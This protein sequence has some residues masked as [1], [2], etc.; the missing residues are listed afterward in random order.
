M[1]I[2]TRLNCNI[3]MNNLETLR[4]LND[5]KAKHIDVLENTET[6]LSVSPLE[7]HRHYTHL[8]A[9]IGLM[10][11]ELEGE[12]D[13]QAESYEEEEKVGLTKNGDE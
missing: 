7:I 13:E 12:L 1:N 6:E 5:M 10:I 11:K 2:I 8:S 3:K 9:R 4:E